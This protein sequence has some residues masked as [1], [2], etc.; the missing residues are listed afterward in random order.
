M[1]TILM[2]KKY[3]VWFINEDHPSVMIGAELK[4]ILKLSG[5]MNAVAGWEE[6][7]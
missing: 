6:T 2:A 1:K 7:Q 5:S 4:R 3:K